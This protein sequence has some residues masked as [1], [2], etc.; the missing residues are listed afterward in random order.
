VLGK[1][2]DDLVE[3][4]SNDLKKLIFLGLSGFGLV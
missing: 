2:S 3:I 1:V 4:N